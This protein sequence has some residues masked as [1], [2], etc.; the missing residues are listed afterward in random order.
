MIPAGRYRSLT[1]GTALLRV[2]G[3]TGSARGG[4]EHATSSRAG[5]GGRTLDFCNLGR[6]IKENGP[7]FAA[8]TDALLPAQPVFG[9]ISPCVCRAQ[10]HALPTAS[11]ECAGRATMWPLPFSR[12]AI[13]CICAGKKANALIARDGL[14]LRDQ[15]H[16]A[17][18]AESM[19]DS[20]PIF[21]CCLRIALARGVA[22]LL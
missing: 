3:L 6:N 16:G 13:A 5:A 7:P 11:L 21:F 4:I 1:D 18:A 15:L 2:P 14:V 8:M 20:K 17:R 9:H 12:Q 19:L 10:P 22:F